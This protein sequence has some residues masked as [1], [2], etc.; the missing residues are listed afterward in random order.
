MRLDSTI[1]SLMAQPTYEQ[2]A[3]DAAVDQLLASSL[4]WGTLRTA[5]VLLKPNLITARNGLL[6][7]TDGRFI[8][9]VARWFAAM[10]AQ[11]A[12]GDSPAFGSA[13]SVLEGINALS[14]LQMLGVPVVEFRQVREIALP[15][16]HKAAMAAVVMDCDLLINLP[17]IKAH[18]QMRV[19]MAVK[20][21]FGCLSGFHKPWWHMVHGGNN[22]R[23]A[24]LL[25]DLLAVLPS[26][27]TLVDGIVAM[28]Q[29]GPVHG[30]P[31]PLG[32]IAF[33][34]NPVAIDTGLLTLLGVDPLH[35]PLWRAS[36]RAGLGGTNVAELVFPLAT[37]AELAVRDFAVPET[38]G[39]VRFDPFR[40]VKNSMKRALLRTFGR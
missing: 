35:S 36:H 16:G 7:C 20:N 25:V 18:S 26:C 2:K 38:L 40:F 17:R 6:A 19:T 13:R 11:V 21:L 27:S 29:A 12:V 30:A 39:P 34:T 8:A 5:R 3:L 32:I 23:F 4:D 9:A 1:V 15:C 22:G 28:H 37:P 31:Y 33:G 14:P 24:E 10:G